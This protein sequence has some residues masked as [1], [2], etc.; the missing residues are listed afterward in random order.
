MVTTDA[1]EDYLEVIYI[2]KKKKGCVQNIDIKEHLNL[3]ASSVSIAIR[4]L[5]EKGYITQDHSDRKSFIFLTDK[6]LKLA[7]EIH[8]RHHFIARVFMAIG[9]SEDTAYKDSCKIEHAL[10]EET[11]EKIKEHCSKHMKDI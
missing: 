11:F 8:E 1:L 2:I 7:E 9:V 6:G 5:K 10:S 4:R 3:T